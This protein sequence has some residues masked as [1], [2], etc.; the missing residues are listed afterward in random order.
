M[1]AAITDTTSPL[2]LTEGEIINV[3]KRT[4]RSRLKLDNGKKIWVSDFY[5]AEKKD[6][7]ITLGAE[8]KV[9]KK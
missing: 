4:Q 3:D 5:L 9:D 7:G 1:R 6:G 2:F 8:M